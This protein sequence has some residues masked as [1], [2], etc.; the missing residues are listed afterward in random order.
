MAL[1]VLVFWD[2]C[3]LVV[4]VHTGRFGSVLTSTRNRSIKVG[5]QNMKS[6]P[7]QPT[8]KTNPIQPEKY[9]VGSVRFFGFAYSNGHQR[10]YAKPRRNIVAQA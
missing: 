5:L 10:L 6:E 8:T 9:R 4:G 1:G 3:D 7:T 2:F